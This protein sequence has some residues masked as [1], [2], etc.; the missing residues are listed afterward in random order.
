MQRPRGLHRLCGVATQPPHPAPYL[1]SCCVGSPEFP[2]S[3]P[4]CTFPSQAHL[5][6]IKK[7]H[8]GQKL[9]DVTVDMALG[10][11]RGITVCE[12]ADIRTWA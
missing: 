8:G 11:M 1:L 6:A 5:K 10:G 9:G 12:G 7:A 3:F 2:P 4:S